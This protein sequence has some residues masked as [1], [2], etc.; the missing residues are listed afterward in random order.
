MNLKELYEMQVK[1]SINGEEWT[2]RIEP[3]AHPRE[4]AII[5]NLVDPTGE[6]KH[7]TLV[8]KEVFKMFD[9]EKVM[10]EVLEPKIR[11]L[12]ARVTH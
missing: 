10:K 6:P 9:K 5:F 4:Y 2:I 12:K 3:A 1:T 11:M 7:F 8:D